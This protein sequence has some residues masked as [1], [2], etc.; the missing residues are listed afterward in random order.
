MIDDKVTGRIKGR[1]IYDSQLTFEPFR[2]WFEWQKQHP[3]NRINKQDIIRESGFLLE[4]QLT[5]EPFRS[6]LKSCNLTMTDIQQEVGFSWTT[7]EK[8]GS[9]DFPFKS[10]TID[11]LYL[12]AK[13]R[14]SNLNLSQI[15]RKKTPEEIAATSYRLGN[16]D[17]IT[18]IGKNPIE[19]IWNDVFP[20]R[21]DILEKLMIMFDLELDQV[22]QF[23]DQLDR[24]MLLESFGPPPPKPINVTRKIGSELTFEP[25]RKW[26]MDQYPNENEQEIQAL[27]RLDM[28]SEIG[29][30]TQLTFEPFRTWMEDC[31][32][33][34][35][36]LLEKASL[37]WTTIHKIRDDNFPIR[38][39]VIEKLLL[40]AES[41][42]FKLKLSQV[43]RKK[44]PEE[45]DNSLESGE[46]KGSSEKVVEQIWTD[47]FPIQ[48]SVFEK[49]MALYDL[50]L[51]Q[52]ICRKPKN[53]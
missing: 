17:K 39:D 36:D 33:T 42:G 47:T 30:V 29:P 15:V 23:R 19:K 9:D 44:M 32:V 1:N 37:S 2:L 51:D 6:W 13:G 48:T 11:K 26:S 34:K 50:E 20:I 52:V 10:D 18:K 45:M 31:G 49:I 53:K 5:F 24:K 14:G 12:F 27:Q 21:T 46:I 7:L 22:V 40:Y 38:S 4:S 8:I 28:E 41:L 35:K 43:I 25:F 16:E 3:L